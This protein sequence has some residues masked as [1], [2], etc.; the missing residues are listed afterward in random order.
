M[1]DKK[2]ANKAKQ[3]GQLI[4]KRALEM[5]FLVT[6]LNLGLKDGDEVDM[7]Y[8]ELAA[9]AAQSKATNAGIMIIAADN[10]N[11][12]AMAVIGK[13]KA[14]ATSALD[15]LNSTQVKG[16]GDADKAKGVLVCD[17]DN[18]QFPMKIKDQVNSEAFAFLRKHDLLPKP[19][20]SDDEAPA[21]SLN[22]L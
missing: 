21:F 8:L 20:S 6:E 9:E 10:K 5:P 22:D 12:L 17:K 4:G 13:D 2:L 7:A 3:E 1:A 18:G 11:V 16:E 14:G 19:E 15:W